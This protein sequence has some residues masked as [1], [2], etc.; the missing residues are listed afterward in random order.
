MHA[1]IGLRSG[2]QESQYIHWLKMTVEQM[3]GIIHTLESELR[4]L[5]TSTQAAR[6][7]SK[8]QLRQNYSLSEDDV[9]FLDQVMVFAQQ[10][11]FRWFK[12]LHTGW[13]I[14]DP[15]KRNSFSKF[16]EN[17]LPICAGTD[18]PSE[19]DNIIAPAIVKKYTNMRCNAKCQQW[20]AKDLH[21]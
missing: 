1:T 16:V 11:L 12:F 19:W 9:M 2:E 15:S 17:N 10:Y 20:R 14:H 6:R 7:S 3:K 18:F 5:L 8:A 4:Q 21:G 13:T